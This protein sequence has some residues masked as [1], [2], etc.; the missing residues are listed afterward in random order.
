MPQGPDNP[1]TI[2][3]LLIDG[4]TADR[5]YFADYLKD[6][7][8]EYHIFEATDGRTGLARYRSRLVDCVVIAVDLP[9]QSGFEVLVQLVP[10][11]SRPN[12]AVIILARHAFRGVHEI[13][14]ENGAQA[15]LV[16]QFMSGDDL[17]SAIRHAI[18][19]VRQIPEED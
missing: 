19:Q 11:A 13:A 18:A 5:T 8:P 4:N 16:K 3:V 2:S 9:D 1:A 12:V 10:V 7:S 14:M 17:D 6:R 15:F